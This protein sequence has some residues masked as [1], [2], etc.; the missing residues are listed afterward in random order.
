MHH[1]IYIIVN[2]T[3]IIVTINTTDITTIIIL[4]INIVR[5]EMLPSF[6][7][8]GCLSLKVGRAEKGRLSLL[9]R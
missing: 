1:N 5:L 8:S 4:S 2:I 3:T 7:S 9:E 6:L